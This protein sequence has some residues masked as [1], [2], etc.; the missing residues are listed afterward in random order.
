MSAFDNVI[1]YQKVKEEL[2]QIIDIFKNPDLYKEMGAKLPHGVLLYG[3]PGMGKTLLATSLIEEIGVKS[4]AVTNSK[5]INAVKAD[6]VEAF[7]NASKETPSI[8]F[9]DDLDKFSPSEGR[10]VDDPVFVAIQSCIDKVK[11]KEI[12]VIATVNRIEKLPDSLKRNGRFDRKLHI[13]NPGQKDAEKIVE[14]YLRKRKVDPNANYDDIAKMISYTSCADLDKIVNE[15][16]ILATYKRKKCVE[17]SDIVDAYLKE[18]YGVSDSIIRGEDDKKS[19]A[20]HEAGHAVVAEALKKGS[21]GLISTRTYSGFTKLWSTLRRRPQ[22]ILLSLGGKVACELYDKGRVASGCSS[23]LE[24]AVSLIESG[25]SSNAT[26]GVSHLPGINGTNYSSDAFKM[27]LESA[28]HD[29]LERYLFLTRDILIKNKDFLFALRDELLAK[30]TLLHSDVAR[31][32]DRYEL[33]PCPGYTSLPGEENPEDGPW[34]MDGS[35]YPPEDEGEEG[36]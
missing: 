34:E 14:F 25:L 35:S 32:R 9:F 29:E 23:D 8:V 3:D 21:V 7:D 4:F 28:I 10:N 18:N 26:L 5:E 19:I 22:C 36:Y 33:V 27:K 30:N 13:G 12:L 2:R 11:D 15:S 6:I 20:L 16:A 17:T 31:I 24:S 1:G